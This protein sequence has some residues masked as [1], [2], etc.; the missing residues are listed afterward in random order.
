MALELLLRHRAKRIMVVCPPGLMLKWQDEMAEKFGLNFTI[1]DSAQLN[2]L[3]RSHGSAANPFRVYP[4]TI[5]SLSWLRGA[6]AERLLHEVTEADGDKR[7]FDLLILDEA[8]HVAP[9][10]PKQRYA[11]DSQQT[12]LIRWLAPHFEHRLFLSAT[13]H[14]GYPE[15]F[16]ALLEI[17]DDQRFARGVDPDPVA[18]K[19]TVIRRMKSQITEADG[20]TPR[21]AK[22][23]AQ[24][25]TVVYPDTERQAHALLNE[26]AALRRRRLTTKRGRAS[27][28]LVTLL[29][30]KRL[31][32]SPRAFAHT[33]GVY[34][35]TVQARTRKKPAAHHDEVPEWMEGFLDDVAAYDDEE[36][37]E[38]EDDA[39]SRSGRIQAELT[40]TSEQEIALLKRMEQWAARYET[41]PDAKARE[42]ITYLIGVCLPRRRALD[43]R[44][45]RG[46]HRI[47][48]HPDLAEGTA[49]PGRAVRRAGQAALRRD[50]HPA[51]GAAQAGVPGTTRPEP[52]P[53]PARHRRGQRGHRPARALPP[54]GQLRHPVQPEQA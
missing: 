36:L 45:G 44:A 2:Q 50:G 37:A 38:A 33:V 41:M 47:P 29:L 34:L 39:A 24:A 46:V 31:F 20:V 27:V 54:A 14:N 21:F 40:D 7:P 51:A 4:L 5:V 28:D 22:R 3:R 18:Q 32:S 35:E 49:R 1:V 9:A 43:E 16:T 23:H 19:D 53:H 6:K 11:V 30:K 26:F 8:H 48:R 17:I 12:K 10:A 42:L 52:G 15:S 13:P 25:I